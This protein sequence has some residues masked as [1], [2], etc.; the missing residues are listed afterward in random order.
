MDIVIV[1]TI[2]FTCQSKPDYHRKLEITGPKTFEG[3]NFIPLGLPPTMLMSDFKQ[4]MKLRNPSSI[5]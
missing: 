1:I 4:Y 5:V 3:L 2:E